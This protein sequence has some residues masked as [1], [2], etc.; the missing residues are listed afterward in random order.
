MSTIQKSFT[1]PANTTAYTAN[2]VVGS[3]ILLDLQDFSDLLIANI[4]LRIDVASGPAGAFRFHFYSGLPPSAHV[5]ND[6]WDLPSGD[7]SVYM[8]YVD[9]ATVVDMGATQ[10]SKADNCNFSISK[11]RFGTPCYVEIVTIAGYTP[12]SADVYSIRL[13]VIPLED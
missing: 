10:I 6:A 2:D 7:R 4:S 3:A 13:T 1:R 8:G 12:G 9:S 5:D 11:G